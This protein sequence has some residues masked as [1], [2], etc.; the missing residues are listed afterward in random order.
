MSELEIIAEMAIL[1]ELSYVN[2]LLGSHLESSADMKDATIRLS[3][4]LCYALMT[5]EIQF[6]TDKESNELKRAISKH[7]SLLAK[8]FIEHLDTVE[9]VN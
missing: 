5:W 4:L 7:A 2:E 8:E 1:D 6:G 3:G 9:E